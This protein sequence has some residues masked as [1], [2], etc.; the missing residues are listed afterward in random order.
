[1]ALQVL[2]TIP[3]SSIWPVPVITD[4]MTPE[5][6]EA[7]QQAINEAIDH[8]NGDAFPESYATI[9][10]VREAGPET[11]V[12]V[13]WHENAD[14]FQAAAQ[15]IKLYEYAA[16]TADLHGTTPEDAAYSWL[17]T[18]PDFFGAIVVP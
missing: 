8:N 9:I 12:C 11:Y 13:R 3:P 16:Q 5:E 1:M 15:P 2:L 17:L 4:D 14:A 10:Y 18:L 7:T 6:V